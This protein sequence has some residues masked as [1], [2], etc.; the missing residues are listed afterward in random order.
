MK[1]TW[2]VRKAIED[3]IDT[4]AAFNRA[5]AWETEKKRLDP[6]TITR[7]VA[8]LMARPALGFYLVAE[9]G[10]CIGASLM[11]TYEWSDWRDGCFWWI[12]SVY[13]VPELRRCGGFSALF[14]AVTALAREDGDVRGLRLYVDHGN[15][16]AQRTYRALG[17]NPGHYTLYEMEY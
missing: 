12:Q 8:R 9:T 7:G 15:D 13:V 17:M 4:I 14:N 16:G 5:M 11:I 1:T 2:T 3:D 10:G 6:E